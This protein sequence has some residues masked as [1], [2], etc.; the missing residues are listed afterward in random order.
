MAI[1]SD[2]FCCCH[3]QSYTTTTPPLTPTLPNFDWKLDHSMEQLLWIFQPNWASFSLLRVIR[4]KRICFCVCT[5]LKRESER[6]KNVNLFFWPVAHKTVHYWETGVCWGWS[7]GT[8]SCPPGCPGTSTITWWSCNPGIKHLIE[9]LH[10]SAGGFSDYR[11]T[12]NR[13]NQ[14]LF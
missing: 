3:G 8:H 9:W 11:R 7:V 14:K 6:E 13:V 2:Q 4:M 1:V 5:K 10:C 12:T